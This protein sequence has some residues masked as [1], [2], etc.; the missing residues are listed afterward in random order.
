MYSRSGKYVCLCVFVCV[1]RRKR[2]QKNAFRRSGYRCVYFC[3]HVM[4]TK[5]K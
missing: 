5:I 4:E 3:V 1:Y 2:K